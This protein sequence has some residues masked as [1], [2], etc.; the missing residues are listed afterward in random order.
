MRLVDAATIARMTSIGRSPSG[1]GSRGQFVGTHSSSAP[2]SAA[3]RTHS[4]K[5]RS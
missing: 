5:S 2:A 1:R 3:A 4:G